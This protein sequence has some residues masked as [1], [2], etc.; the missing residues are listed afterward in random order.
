MVGGQACAGASEGSAA[1]PSSAPGRRPP[2]PSAASSTTAFSIARDQ[3][4]DRR[5]RRSR[6]KSGA[7]DHAAHEHD[8]DAVARAGARSDARTR[9]AGARTRWRRWSSRI[10]RSRVP[11]AS[12]TARSL[13]RPDSCRWF[14]ELHDQD[15]VLRH[16]A[17][18]RD[19]PDLAVDV[20]R[21]ETQEREQQRAEDRER[22]RAGDDRRTDRGSSRTARRARDR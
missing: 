9:A 16:Q 7:D 17:D 14:G 19:Q 15:P 18:Q 1:R 11:A 5:A 6:V 3:H 4:V 8:A 22:R 2:R 21:G 13:S 20:E 10:G 12:I